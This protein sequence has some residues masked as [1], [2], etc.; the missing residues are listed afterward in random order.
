MS[1]TPTEGGF[2]PGSSDSADCTD[3]LAYGTP[4][5]IY[6]YVFKSDLPKEEDWA[7]QCDPRYHGTAQIDSLRVNTDIQGPG[8]VGPILVNSS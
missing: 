3:K 4:S 7:G 8:G 6:S 1:E 2:V 5:T